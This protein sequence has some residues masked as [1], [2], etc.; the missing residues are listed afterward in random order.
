MN[1]QHSLLGVTKSPYEIKTERGMLQR[2]LTR[3][4]THTK[5]QSFFLFWFICENI[6]LVYSSACVKKQLFSYA[7]FL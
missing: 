6:G 1:L 4:H 5:T 7:I 2:N 3:T